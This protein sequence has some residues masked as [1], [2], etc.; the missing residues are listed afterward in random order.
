MAVLCGDAFGVEL[1]A[2]DRFCFMGE[3]HDEAIFGFR[4]DFEVC[5]KRFAIND[6][7][8]IARGVKRGRK[9]GEN[10]FALM[11][12]LG[13]FSMEGFGGTDDISAKGLSYGLHAKADPEQGG[14]VFGAGGD[15]GKADA[16]MIRIGWAG[17][18]HDAAWFQ[19]DAFL[20]RDFVVAVD[21]SVHTQITQI[22]DEVV[23]KAVIVIN[24]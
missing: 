2:V 24:Q 10:A 16:G 15:E 6:E 14:V 1:D 18:D 20:H 19:G 22:L 3:A 12:H 17:G 8:M 4:R 9:S 21:R 5:G 11:V 13:C 23:G 7:R